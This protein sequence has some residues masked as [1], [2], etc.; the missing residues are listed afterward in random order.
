MVSP[1]RCRVSRWSGAR[2]LTWRT[3]YTL[4]QKDFALIA[5]GIAQVCSLQ[6]HGGIIT[7]ADGDK[8]IDSGSVNVALI[9]Q[10]A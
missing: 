10:P 4:S 6:R 9:R 1:T 7:F 3:P 8:L 5:V 2:A